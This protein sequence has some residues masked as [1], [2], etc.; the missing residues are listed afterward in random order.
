MDTKRIAKGKNKADD[1]TMV[2]FIKLPEAENSEIR[3]KLSR[4]P[5]QPK[6]CYNLAFI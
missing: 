1:I 4:L 5:K 2:C 3:R 6:R